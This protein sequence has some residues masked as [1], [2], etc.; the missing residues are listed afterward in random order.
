[1][2]T[3][4]T[5]KTASK[6][7]AEWV[8][9]PTSSF[10]NPIPNPYNFTNPLSKTVLLIADNDYVSEAT[11][12]YLDTTLCVSG[13]KVTK[14]TSI[15][16]APL[17]WT[18]NN[19]NKEEKEDDDDDH[20]WEY[21]LDLNDFDCI[22]IPSQLNGDIWNNITTETK[23][24]IKSF[25]ERG[26]CLICCHFRG[27]N[28]INCVC[29]VCW[30]E[31]SVKIGAS[32][33]VKKD[34]DVLNYVNDVRGIVNI[35]KN[36]VIY[37]TKDDFTTVGFKKYGKGYCYYIGHDFSAIWEKTWNKILFNSIKKILTNSDQEIFNLNFGDIDIDAFKNLNIEANKDNDN[38]Q[39]DIYLEEFEPDFQSFDQNGNN[40]N[41]CD[42][43]ENKSEQTKNKDND[44]K[45][46]KLK[47]EDKN[48]DVIKSFDDFDDLD[49]F[50][51]TDNNNDE[52]KSIGYVQMDD[53]GIITI[54][55]DINNQILDVKYNT[56]PLII[57]KLE[58]INEN[59]NNVNVIN[60]QSSDD[61]NE[62]ENEMNIA[63]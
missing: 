40:N 55:N 30:H 25:V 19:D 7:N 54:N 63:P 29:N 23:T 46:G 20:F 47:T 18:S 57:K 9:F 8:G 50:D 17:F 32:Y 48:E 35:D 21:N 39:K 12:N 42:D 37:K 15:S 5:T 22:L 43:V 28:F 4:L 59:D 38:E 26:G 13:F 27:T 33:H 3:S 62:A 24:K 61:N 53:N 60:E 36:D 52:Y 34:K 49:G 1:M 10:L 51:D 6:L 16:S 56:N 41:N 11:A 44:I 14:F 45:N 58:S 31:I 2:A